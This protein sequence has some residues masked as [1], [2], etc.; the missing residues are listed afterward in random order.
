[1]ETAEILEILE[2]WNFWKKGQET[3]IERK[4]Y[5]QKLDEIG[6]AGQVIA[7]TGVRRS[8]KSTIMR[9]YIKNLMQNG[10]K[11]ENILYVNFEDRRFTE[12]SLALLN[13]IYDLYLEHLSPGPKPYILLDEV[14]KIEGWE[15]FARTMHELGKA[16]VIVSGS[17]SKLLSSSISSVLTGR[18]LDMEVYPLDFSEFLMF[19]GIYL[20]DRLDILSQRHI[21]KS[22][23][24]EYL[25]Y[26]GFP[27]V[28]LKNMK[29]ELLQT[30]FEDIIT[31]D[32]VERHAVTNIPKLKS[33]AKFYLSNAG[34]RISFN[35][36]SK[37]LG[38][39]LDTVER[40]SYYLAESYLVSFIKK[41]SYSV[42][43]QERTQ[44][45][46]YAVD[47]GLKNAVGF[48]FSRDIGW[49]YQNAIANELMKRHGAEGVFYWMSVAQEE[50][51]FVVKP[52]QKVEQLVQ[53]CYSLELAETKKKEI[54]ALLKASRELKCG[55][56]LV[57]TENKEG[58]EKF[59]RKKIK[60]MPLW[61]WLL[62]Q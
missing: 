10:V 15:K 31:K 12:L 19:K 6:N 56:L 42:K 17:N 23:L 53:V 51:D 28:C 60:Y 8:G 54:N 57:I 3:G 14:H 33:L 41:F 44:A 20:K 1:M 9:Q 27:L 50:V 2:D 40:Y 35:A 46:V 45:V 49:L 21:I 29:D 7:I 43:E 48:V 30:Y 55:N 58:E 18:H 13:K 47:N 52:K 26:G 61:K 24:N 16:K 39:S 25:K 38:L 32:V 62:K 22:A 11:P 59:G 4:E 5:L 36:L 34:R 37:S